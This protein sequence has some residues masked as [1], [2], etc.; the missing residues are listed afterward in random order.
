LEA[1]AG[2]PADALIAPNNI[3]PLDPRAWTADQL[4]TLLLTN[5]HDVIFLAGH[6]SADSALAAD[7][8][9]QLKTSDVVASPV[10]LTNSIIFSAGCHSGYNT[11]NEHGIPGAT[12]VLD[13]AQAFARKRATFIGG[14]G[15]QYGH[16]DF[17]KYGERLYTLFSEELRAGNG[18]ISVGQ[19]LVRAKQRYLAEAPQLH[20]LDEKTLLQAT[21]FGLPMLSVDMSFGRAGVTPLSLDV[22][23]IGSLNSF[24]IDPGATL[25]LEYF[26]L[27]VSPT[28][29]EHTV[30]MTNVDD[31][32]VVSATYYSGSNGI[33]TNP[34]EPVLP[35]EIVNVSAPGTTMVA[36]GFVSGTY[37][38]I[39]NILPLTG[40]PT[41]E[42][43][44]VHV[45]FLSDVFFPIKFFHANY[46]DL[47]T[48]GSNTY[49]M[50]TPAQHRSMSPGSP[51]N[52]LRLYNEVGLRL[53]YSNNI[54]EYGGGSIP[55]LSA[56]PTIATISAEPDGL[57]NVVF[58]LA[59]FG[60]PAAGIQEVWVT[61]TA[62][63][64]PYYGSWQS[65][66]LT[67]N[68]A[69]STLWEGT[70]PLNG[71][72]SEDMRFIAQA[73]NG[74][75]RVT[76]M[77]NGGAY[78]IPGVTFGDPDQ[79]APT[80]LILDP[81]PSSG[82][83]GASETFSAVL[84]S[85]GT[86]LQG[87]VVTFGLGQQLRAA[88]TDSNGRATV[89]LPLISIHGQY[90]L[91]A[92]FEG[93]SDYASSSDAT[94]FEITKQP[95]NIVLQIESLPG[96]SSVLATLSDVAGRRL[97]EQSI[98]L[99]ISGPNGEFSARIITNLIGQVILNDIP[100][101]PGTYNVTAYFGG[102]VPLPG[103]T[104][105]VA[106][107]SYNPSTASAVLEILPATG[108][109]TIKKETKPGNRN[110]FEFGGDLGDFT[111]DDGQQTQFTGRPAGIY[112]VFE[113]RAS[114]PKDTW[115]LLWVQCTDLDTN[116]KFFFSL[117]DPQNPIQVDAEKF[118]VNIP[119][120][121]EQNLFC[122]FHNEQV[123]Y[124]IDEP[125]PALKDHRL[126][127]PLVRR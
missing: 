99:I 125:V 65:L 36:T 97:I 64:G 68:G 91:S 112:Q 89:T 50:L 122:L 77:T 104:V 21:V 108:N 86:P 93:N 124:E 87:Q 66:Y 51:T 70:L 121:G 35:L 32:S 106:S 62:T 75:G 9:T 18:P 17:L 12:D 47:L 103:A 61:Y 80:T 120:A 24:P 100:L 46:F 67:Q 40:A 81:A 19:A 95:T 22:S 34:M 119:L 45:P 118:T 5:R 44:G 109:I 31:N 7:F 14:T 1:G 94:P 82:A 43:R 107:G 111:L 102:Q 10:N 101:P 126:F 115:A 92:S 38:D 39:P 58:Q 127:L 59:V 79:Q 56:A 114:F 57:G 23:V 15:Y 8:Q 73:V 26:D 11:V 72:P 53:Y 105:N 84:T 110:G 54:T 98:F 27:A 30:P 28:L 85:N 78:Y 6:F 83:Y 71:T 49:L 117:D 37:A 69:D 113:R 20:D 25:G 63:S 4:A 55:A 76:M 116:D 2:Q 16:T 33:A 52:M 74:V 60:N 13:W 96:Q 123:N 90:Q 41:T 3:S 48:G 29:V 88:V 42:I